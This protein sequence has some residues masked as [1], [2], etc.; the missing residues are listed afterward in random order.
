MTD[1]VRE[2]KKRQDISKETI[3]I[4]DRC[5]GSIPHMLLRKL[6]GRNKDSYDD[7]IRSFALTLHFYSPE[8]YEFVRN[9]FGHSLPHISTLRKRAQAVDGKPGFTQT[10]FEVSTI[11]VKF[12]IIYFMCSNSL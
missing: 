4:I 12:V 11:I 9:S 2:L 10:A 7:T 8:A 5:F 6:K 3:G 1:V